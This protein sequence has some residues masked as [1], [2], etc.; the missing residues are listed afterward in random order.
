MKRMWKVFFARVK[1]LF[2]DLALAHSSNRAANKAAE[3]FS[4]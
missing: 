3:K 2:D 1:Q 4:V